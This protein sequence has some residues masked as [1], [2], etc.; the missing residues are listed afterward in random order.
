MEKT[1]VKKNTPT[2]SARAKKAAPVSEG[3]PK[4]EKVEKKVA[5]TMEA[6]V[7]DQKGKEVEKITLPE[8]IFGLRWNADLVHQTVQSLLSSAR[9]AIAH[10]KSRADVRG[11]GKKPWQQKGTGR[12]RHG[13]TRSPIWVGGGVTHGPRNDKNF[14][15]KVNKKMKAMALFTI[16]SKKYRDGEILFIDSLTFVKP[17]TK[18]ALETL[19]FL[20]GI[21][22][23][24]GI[25]GKKTNSTL[26]TIS[27][28]D[29]AVEKS[30]SN[31]GNM[32]VQ[33]IRNLNPIKVLKYKYLVISEPKE[34]LK[35]IESK[36]K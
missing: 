36:Q 19:S 21:K 10:T 7:Y 30:F 1:T 11:G 4:S 32:E 28:K 17:K 6:T 22:G 9:N 20:K 33:E 23:F 27:K 14:D 34:S 26:I 13:S 25:V 2:T 3:I 15:K 29:M 8:D 18:E 24:G 16:L 5:T 31:F 35:F 12:A